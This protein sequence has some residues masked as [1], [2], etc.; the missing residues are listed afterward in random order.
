MGIYL[1]FIYFSTT[2]GKDIYDAARVDGC[3]EWQVFVK[4]A[5]PLAAP[6]IALVTFFSF[7]R[8]W[9]EFLLPYI[10]LNSDQFPLPVGLAVLASAAPELNPNTIG[11]FD[12]GVSEVI[13]ATL[14]TM[15]PV[16]LVLLFTQRTV[17]R[18]ATI[19]GGALRG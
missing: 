8:N 5:L 7:M 18:G 2:I 19:L 13:L 16:L 11:Q 4:I 12:I 1:T 3:T 17:L 6:I 10:M 9:G 14:L 15:A